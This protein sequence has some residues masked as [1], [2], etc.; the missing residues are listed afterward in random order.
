VREM[1]VAHGD[2]RTPPV[3]GSE[4]RLAR[5][6]AGA[7]VHRQHHP[8]NVPGKEDLWSLVLAAIRLRLAANSL[9][10]LPDPDPQPPQPRDVL[11][12]ATRELT[13]FYEQVADQ[14]GQPRGAN[15]APGA[16]LLRMH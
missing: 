14:V 15:R 8:G 9:A 4:V 10:G 6:G 1:P 12:Q 7:A 5:R 16:R 2:E 11:G 13:G 3:R